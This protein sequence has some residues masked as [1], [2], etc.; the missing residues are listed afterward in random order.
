MFKSFHFR[1]IFTRRIQPIFNFTI[2]YGTPYIL[3]LKLKRVKK[4]L[5]MNF[6]QLDNYLVSFPTKSCKIYFVTIHYVLILLLDNYWRGICVRNMLEKEDKF[7]RILTQLLFRM[8]F[9]MRDEFENSS[10]GLS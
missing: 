1:F 5:V 10:L 4:R 6:I 8:L 2:H 3:R 9:M 7:A